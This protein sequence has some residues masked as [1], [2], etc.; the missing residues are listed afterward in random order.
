MFLYK[1]ILA[2]LGLRSHFERVEIFKQVISDRNL[3][4]MDDLRNFLT[5]H[6]TVIVSLAA[7]GNPN[8]SLLK[9]LKLHLNCSNKWLFLF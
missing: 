3:P 6:Q 4:V 8:I 5:E 2:E 7:T 9:Q 1:L